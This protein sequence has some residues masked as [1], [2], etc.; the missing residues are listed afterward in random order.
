MNGE[1]C[2]MLQIIPPARREHRRHRDNVM[3]DA[4]RCCRLRSLRPSIL[5]V[6]HDRTTTIRASVHDIQITL[7]ITVVLV[8]LVIFVFLRNVWAT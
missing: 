3:R 8:I 2:I 7:L 4:S 1:P 6:E 5:M